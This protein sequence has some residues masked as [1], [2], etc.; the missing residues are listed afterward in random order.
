MGLS[1]CVFG[2]SDAYRMEAGIAKGRGVGVGVG[3]GVGA[4]VGGGL[5]VGVGVGV[6]VGFGDGAGPGPGAGMG[7]GI[8][9]SCSVMAPAAIG[10]PT[11]ATARKT[12]GNNRLRFIAHLLPCSLHRACHVGVDERTP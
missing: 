5:G 10:T 3:V 11:T 7:G 2:W 8:W 12:A 4:G 9:S 1:S 6:G